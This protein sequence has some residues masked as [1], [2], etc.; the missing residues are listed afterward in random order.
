MRGIAT[1]H[2]L[3]YDDWGFEIYHDMVEFLY[4]A[5]LWMARQPRAAFH[6]LAA[7]YHG[8]GGDGTTKQREYTL[9]PQRLCLI[10]HFSLYHIFGILHGSHHFLEPNDLNDVGKLP[11]D[12]CL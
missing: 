6:P 3:D 2:R 5:S 1:V 4:A 12:L 8:F 11:S 7:R 9:D 10:W